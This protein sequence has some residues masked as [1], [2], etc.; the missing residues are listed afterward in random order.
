MPSDLV[1]ADERAA[2]D[3]E[4][5]EDVGAAFVTDAQAPEAVQPGVRAFHR[6]AVTSKCLTQNRPFGI[7]LLRGSG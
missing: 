3:V 4:G 5:Q 2:E 7:R 6:P 1:E